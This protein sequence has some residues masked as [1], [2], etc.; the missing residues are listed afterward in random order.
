MG[1]P[2]GTTVK[3]RL[4]ALRAPLQARWKRTYPDGDP[5]EA[6]LTGVVT[7]QSV[8][9]VSV[10]LSY[11]DRVFA[12]DVRVRGKDLQVL[13]QGPGTSLAHEPETRPTS[14]E[15]L[16]LATLRRAEEDSDAESDPGEEDP[17]A[18][19]YGP[20]PSEYRGSAGWAAIGDDISF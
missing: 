10:A 11:E 6:W 1:L 17:S 3:C 20:P 15:D 9:W 5:V 4:T 18:E 12:S 7:G 8:A 19:E 13:A 14:V 16:N 2:V